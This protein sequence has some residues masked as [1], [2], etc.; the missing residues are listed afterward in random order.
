MRPTSARCPSS[1]RQRGEDLVLDIDGCDQDASVSARQALGKKFDQQ[2]PEAGI[3]I[4]QPAHV[5]GLPG[6]P[7]K[8]P[9]TSFRNHQAAVVRKDPQAL[10]AQGEFDRTAIARR[11]P[12]LHET[13]F[14]EAPQV[15]L[16]RGD[17]ADIEQKQLL[18]GERLAAR[19]IVADFADE[20]MIAAPAEEMEML[21]LERPEYAQAFKYTHRQTLF[22]LSQCPTL[23]KLPRNGKDI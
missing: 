11:P 21:L 4:A 14:L 13:E 2:V 16:D 20:A 17:R 7:H 18:E 19:L 22:P 12:V 6:M 1:V 15:P 3:A 5:A 8:L 9:R 23:S 10:G